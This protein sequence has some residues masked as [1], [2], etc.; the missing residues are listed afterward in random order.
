MDCPK[1]HSPMESVT[2]GEEQTTIDRCT[3]CGGIWFDLGEVERL[4]REWMSEAIDRGNVLVGRMHDRITDCDCPRCGKKMLHLEHADPPH[5]GYEACEEHGIY[6]D[7]GEFIDTK[8]KSL[9]QEI[10]QILKEQ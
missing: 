5:I 2:Y 9:L 4:R 8:Y 1:C 6:L 10:S 7:A 3:A